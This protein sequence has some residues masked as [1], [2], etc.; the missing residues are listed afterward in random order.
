MKIIFRGE[1]GRGE[2]GSRYKLIYRGFRVRV[3]VR[4]RVEIFITDVY[5]MY[6]HTTG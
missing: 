6:T 1:G 2:S 3:R 4:V 5:G